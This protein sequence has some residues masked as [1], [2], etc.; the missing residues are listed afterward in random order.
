MIQGVKNGRTVSSVVGGGKT[1]T[2]VREISNRD[3]FDLVFDMPIKNK[4]HLCYSAVQER[5]RFHVYGLKNGIW[6]LLK[7]VETPN[8]YDSI[9]M[10]VDINGSFD[11]IKVTIIR[12]EIYANSCKYAVTVSSI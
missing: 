6:Q 3:Q 12:D 10:I 5:G 8:S 9:G 1:I 7:T 11:N 2:M 4:L